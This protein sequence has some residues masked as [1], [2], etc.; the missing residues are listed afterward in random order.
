MVTLTVTRRSTPSEV[1]A[2]SDNYMGIVTARVAEQTSH[3]SITALAVRVPPQYAA[4]VN[5]YMC[6]LFVTA[7]KRFPQE[8]EWARI[9][10]AWCLLPRTLSDPTWPS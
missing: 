10:W 1:T 8:N 4:R 9:R 3:T 5:V 2:R 6:V 7:V